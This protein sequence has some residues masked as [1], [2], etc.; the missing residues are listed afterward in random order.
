MT[1]IAT[2]SGHL[3]QLLD[4]GL[5]SVVTQGRHRYYRIANPDVAAAIEAVMNLAEQS[6]HR[7]VRT[8]PRDLEL[9][10][11]RVCYDHL[12]G[13]LAVDLFDRLS[14]GSI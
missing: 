13:G 5:L 11:A 6:S 10:K 3:A 2:S 1:E 12:A 4:R 8:G 7:R 14:R 9:R